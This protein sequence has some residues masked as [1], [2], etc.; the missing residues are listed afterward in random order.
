MRRILVLDGHPH[1]DRDHYIHALASAYVQGAEEMHNVRRIDLAKLD[2]PVLRD[3]QDW[4]SGS[5][6]ESL[7]QVQDAIGWAEHI[8]ILYPL[9][10][11]DCPALLKALLEQV[12]RPGFALE[13]LES[14]M[15]RKML[16]GKTARLV[17]TMGM[18]AAAYA[19]YFRAHS[20]KSLKR[21]VLQFAGVSPVR[22]SLV[23]SVERSD[24]YRR[25]W[26]RKVE[27]LGRYGR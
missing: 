2:F 9:W 26:L 16:N 18:P 21:N 17:V 14:G 27:T 23:G 1:D 12:T 22:V 20:V 7:V 3:P 4:K 24:K 15:Y 11:G 8:V 25:K 19:L 6:P 10:M 13:P 5:V